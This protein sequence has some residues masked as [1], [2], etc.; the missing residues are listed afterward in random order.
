MPLEQ[1]VQDHVKVGVRIIEPVS[2]FPKSSAE[3]WSIQ[4]GNMSRVLIADD[5]RM[6]RKVFPGCNVANLL[7]GAERLLHC[8]ADQPIETNARQIP[9]TLSL[10]L[11]ATGDREDEKPDCETLLR[12]AD[13][14]LYAAKA[15]GR[16][17]VETAW[18][19]CAAGR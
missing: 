3:T 16:N 10:G 14:A 13:E 5:D 19:S 1:S 17:R 6:A 8:I 2:C 15:R 7:V 9:V 12:H 18:A 4:A 11:A